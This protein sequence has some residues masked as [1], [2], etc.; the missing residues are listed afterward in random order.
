M[1]VSETN[2]RHYFLSG[3]G[4]MGELTR[5]FD[6]SQTSLGNPDQWPHSLKTTLGILLHSSFPMFLFW[7][8][9]LTCFYNDAY[10]PSLGSN[11]KHPAVGK[12]A[13]D[14]W[15]EIWDFI[16]PLIKKV[17][18]TN[19]AVWYE[20]QLLPIYRNGQIEDVYWTFSYSPVYGD[21][22]KVSGVFVTCTETTAKVNNQKSLENSELKFRK[23]VEE[24]PLATCVLKGKE[25][26]VDV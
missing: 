3:G 12:K 23:L 11:G 16:G 5:S 2:H 6:W 14:V 26:I 13:Q 22:G 24:M 4:E 8:E 7:G 10:R 20:D 9:D 19:E 25:L 17:L 21:E 15:P 18:E 1:N